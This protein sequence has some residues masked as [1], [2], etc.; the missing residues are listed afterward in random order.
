VNLY[1]ALGLQKPIPL[2]Q[3][4]KRNERSLS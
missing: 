4:S 1:D 3:E 2:V